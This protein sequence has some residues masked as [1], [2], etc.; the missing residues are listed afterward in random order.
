MFLTGQSQLTICERISAIELVLLVKVDFE[1]KSCASVY[2]ISESFLSK[3][4]FESHYFF[5]EELSF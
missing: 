3:V 1:S 5:L 2:A 4:A